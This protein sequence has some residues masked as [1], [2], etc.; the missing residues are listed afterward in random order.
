ML[1]TNA[2]EIEMER[3][4]LTEESK[5]SKEAIKK[6]VEMRK[7]TFDGQVNYSINFY[8]TFVSLDFI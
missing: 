1:M 8:C 5:E 7:L 2:V 3:E 4:K 6:E